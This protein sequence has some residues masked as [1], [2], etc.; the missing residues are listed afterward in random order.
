MIDVLI[1]GGG[2]IGCATAVQLLRAEPSL[3]V[4]VVE[5]DPSYRHAATPRASGGVRQLFSL[6]EHIALTQYTLT[7]VADWREFVGAGAPELHWRPNGYLFIAGPD[8]ADRLAAAHARQLDNGVRADWLTPA[9]LAAR[10]P[11]LEIRDLAGAVHSPDDG[12]LDPWAMLSG[13]RAAAQRL[14]AEFQR[15]RVCDFIVRDG[16]V[17]AARLVSGPRAAEVFIDAAGCWAA[18]LAA[19]VGMPVP[20]EPMRRWEHQIETPVDLSD[21]PFVKDPA[22]LAVRPQGDGLSTGL[23]DF[24]QFGDDGGRGYFQRVVWPALA[25]RLPALDR[26]R[27]RATTTGHYDQNRLDG[28]MILGANPRGPANFLLAC[29]FSGHGL[30]HALGVGRALTELVRHGEF[31]TLDLSRFGYQ[32]VLDNRPY[33]E[34]S[35]R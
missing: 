11:A 18:E 15:E 21:L 24:A 35:I 25:H 13:L 4:L 5:P 22:G 27:L 3:R 1:A 33:A 20:V 16:V 31:R 26:L 28:S 29:G 19:G 8:H 23:V 30:M 7:V 32:R 17:R 34:T 2:I 10:F 14:G 6:P 12:W 9:G